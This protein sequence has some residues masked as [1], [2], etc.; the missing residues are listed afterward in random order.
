MEAC[1]ETVGENNTFT[2]IISKR[3]YVKDILFGI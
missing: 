1:Q 3:K 2:V